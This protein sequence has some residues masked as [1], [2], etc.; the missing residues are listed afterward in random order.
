MIGRFKALLGERGRAA[1][2]AAPTP[3]E[4]H[5]AAAVL[6]VEAA[7]LDEQ[8]DAAERDKVGEIIRRHFGATEAEAQALIEAAEAVHDG[9]SGLVRYTRVIKERFSPEERVEVIEMLWEVAYADGVLHDYEANLLRR[10]AGLIYVSD[11]D[12]GAARKR[13]LE[14]LGHGDSTGR[15]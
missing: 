6:M 1:P 3:E 14:R 8:F 9:A 4:K 2:A 10:V 13:V 7:L 15:A 11:R 5:L 12:R